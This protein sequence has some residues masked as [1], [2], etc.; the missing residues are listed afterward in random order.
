MVQVLATYNEI[1]TRRLIEIA[2]FLTLF[3]LLG[4]PSLISS[5]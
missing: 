4:Q 1:A 5:R 2:F 3:F